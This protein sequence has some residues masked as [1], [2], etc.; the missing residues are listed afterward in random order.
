MKDEELISLAK[1]RAQVI[2]DFMSSTM[3]TPAERLILH[4]EGTIIPVDAVGRSGSRA[5]FTLGAK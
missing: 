3:K 2:R 5:D 1:N 4:G